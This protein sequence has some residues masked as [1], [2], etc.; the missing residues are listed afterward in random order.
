MQAHNLESIRKRL[1]QQRPLTDEELRVLATV[2]EI[3]PRRED[4]SVMLEHYALVE[5]IAQRLLRDAIPRQ[6]P[7]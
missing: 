7:H 6:R 5:K 3:G 1:R 4:I 2:V